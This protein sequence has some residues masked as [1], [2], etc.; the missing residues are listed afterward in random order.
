MKNKN[1]ITGSG[2][3]VEQ[4]T[5]RGSLVSLIGVQLSD[6]GFNS[7]NLIPDSCECSPKEATGEKAQVVRCLFPIRETQME[8]WASAWLS[9]NCCGCGERKLAAG[10]SLFAFQANK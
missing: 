8:F 3:L 4:W 2:H 10:K 1:K 9:P 6:P 7:L 5:S